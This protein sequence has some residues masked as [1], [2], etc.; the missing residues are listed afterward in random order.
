MKTVTKILLS[1]GLLGACSTATTL[2][3]DLED[4][5]D[6]KRDGSAVVVE[7]GNDAAL[8]SVRRQDDLCKVI[9][10][11]HSWGGAADLDTFSSKCRE[12]S[13]KIQE[14]TTSTLYAHQRDG[15]PV[16]LAMKVEVS[17]GNET[18]DCGLDREWVAEEYAFKWQASCDFGGA[19]QTAI[20]AHIKAIAEG[21][22]YYETFYEMDDTRAVAWDEI[23]EAVRAVAQHR[24]ELHTE[25]A[26]DH[27]YLNDY[28]E[29][30]G[31][32]PL[33]ILKDGE[34][35]G[36]MLSID[37]YSD[38]ASDGAGEHLFINLRAELVD[39]VY[40]TG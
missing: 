33:A 23:P 39:S 31:E 34:V 6:G 7:P 19:S 17:D 9:A 1:A 10:E 24:I 32:A 38:R 8:W 22:E 40:W 15:R 28:A 25:E 4:D 37:Y 29:R 35:V 18:W 36:Y 13:F 14:F 21:G 3:L 11:G 27:G 2:D 16:T 30:S 12:H 26:R 5:I 20:D